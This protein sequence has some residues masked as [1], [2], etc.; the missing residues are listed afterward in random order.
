MTD[1][2][3]YPYTGNLTWLKTSTI[4]LVTHGSRAYGLNTATSD[5]DVKGVAIPPAPYFLG[6]N[7]NFE[8]AV[9]S[10]PD[11]VVY[12]ITKFFGL[13]ADCNPNIIEVLW[14]DESDH[15]VVTPLGRRLLDARGLFLSRKARFTFAGYAHAQLKRIQLHH[16]W[17]VNPL[18]EKPTRA[19][20]GLPERTVIPQDQLAAAQSSIEKKLEHWN[21][22]D[23]TGLDPA[24]RIAVQSAMAEMLAEIKISSDNVWASAARNLGYDENFI[25]LLDLERRYLSRQRD[26]ES[27]QSWLKNRNPKRAALEAKFGYDCYADDTEFLTEN[28]WKRYDDIGAGDRLATIFFNDSEHAMGHRKALGIEH[29][30]YTDRFEGTFTGDLY[31][32]TGNHLD[33]LVT[34]NHRMLMRKKERASRKTG[35]WSLTEAAHLPDTFEFLHLASPVIKTHGTSRFFEGLPIPAATYLSLMGWYLSDG[36]PSF[37]ANQQPKEIRISQK[38][39]GKL[40]GSMVKFSRRYKALG[41]SLYHYERKADELPEL[42]ALAAEAAPPLAARRAPSASGATAREKTAGSTSKPRA[43]V[44]NP[45]KK[46][47]F[48]RVE[49]LIEAV[50]GVR[51]P[52]I[53]ERLASDCGARKEK[54]IPRWVFQ[55]SKRQMEILFDAMVGG[56]G[57]IRQTSKKSILYYASLPGLAN[58]VHELAVRCGWETSLYG[59]YESKGLTMYQVHVHKDAAQTR[60]L[61]RSAAVSKVPVKNRRIVCFTVPNGTL[62]VR[63]NGHVSFQGNSKHGMHLVRLMRMCREILETGKVQVK[64]PDR[65]EL[66]AIRNGAW[67]YEQLLEWSAAQEAQMDALYK[68]SSLPHSPDRKALDQLCV[69]LVQEALSAS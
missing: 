13:A 25:R 65:E 55:L 40:Y 58:D 8:Q 16:R 33:L 42:E 31:Q 36:S 32:F 19:E 6:F 48:F 49:S 60:T 14:G 15:R 50:L 23:M 10:E 45:A 7:Q 53:V 67:T 29:Q 41:C 44:A 18:T 1:D 35:A 59:P 68:A 20:F 57:T 39:G 2:E 43:K 26:W 56:D 30:P 17:L 37:K 64:R 61:V 47:L 62:V 22:D 54:R 5:T 11:M 28:G 66:L 24:A 9:T 12:S 51:T 63:R 4:L 21:L 52:A 34:P 69:A 38:K 46:K 3:I 27:Y